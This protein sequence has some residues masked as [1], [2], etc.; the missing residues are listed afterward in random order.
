MIKLDTGNK[1]IIDETIKLK[2]VLVL[3]YDVNHYYY[4]QII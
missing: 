2:N 3:S 1:L 4:Y